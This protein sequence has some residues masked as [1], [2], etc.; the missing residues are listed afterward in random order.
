MVSS[1]PTNGGSKWTYLQQVA[2]KAKYILELR[3]QY[4]GPY[5]NFYWPSEFEVSTSDLQNYVLEM[6][7]T[8]SNQAAYASYK[9][10][11]QTV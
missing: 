11:L 1:L 2:C 6:G 10:S 5:P 8:N 7:S 4:N 9:S 3:V